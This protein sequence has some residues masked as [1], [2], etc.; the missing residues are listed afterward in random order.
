MPSKKL[1]YNLVDIK[2]FTYSCSSNVFIVISIAAGYIR[3]NCLR[4]NTF[5]IIKVTTHKSTLLKLI[6]STYSNCMRLKKVN[7]L[8]VLQNCI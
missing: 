4:P 6:N 2:D 7:T 1:Q 3:P 8:C 5:Q